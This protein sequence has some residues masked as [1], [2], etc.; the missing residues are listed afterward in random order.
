MIRIFLF[1]L[2]TMLLIPCASAQPAL[3]GQSAA[4]YQQAK[5]SGRFYSKAEKLKPDVWPTSDGQSFLVVWKATQSPKRWIVSL[6]GAGRPAKGFA[7][8]DFALWQPNLQD[9]DVGLI[10]LQ[11]WLGKGS[12][13]QDFYTPEQIYREISIALQKLGVQPGA[14]MLHGF[15]RG[16]TNTFAV[17]A[18]DAGRGKHYFSLA[19]ASSGGVALN[20]PPTE[21]ILAGD[22]GSHPL[23]GTRWI[24]VAGAKDPN[25][26]R[27]G[28]AGMRLTASWLKNQGAV[29]IESIEDRNEGHGALQRNSENVR[30]VLDLFFSLS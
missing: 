20:Y 1:I 27:D 14:V 21:A 29:V 12:E 25:P 9:R 22:Y 16:S 6:H 10:C 18:L 5:E 24:T 28:V 26:D 30:R 3:T 15:S 4:L 23:K 19:V 7:T 11:W 17:V 2:F 8:D 13:P